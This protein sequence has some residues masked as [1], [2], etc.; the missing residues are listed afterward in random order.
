M[1]WGAGRELNLEIV[2]KDPPA[3]EPSPVRALGFPSSPKWVL[4]PD[5]Y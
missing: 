1:S 2:V 4:V 3:W 5:A